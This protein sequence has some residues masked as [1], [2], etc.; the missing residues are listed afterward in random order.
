MDLRNAITAG[1]LARE[2]EMSY[3][4]ASKLLKRVG[5]GE[6]LAGVT[7]YDRRFVKQYLWMKN[8]RLL[9]FLELLPADVDTKEIV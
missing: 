5:G 8:V 2:L 3:T 9:D 7:V 6:N 4:G 1:E